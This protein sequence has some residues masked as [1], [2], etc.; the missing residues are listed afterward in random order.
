MKLAAKEPVIKKSARWFAFHLVDFLSMILPR[1]YPIRKPLS[2]PVR[3]IL[4][5]ELA[6]LGDMLLTTPLL[7]G[8]KDC[9]P[10]AKTTV[11]CTPWAKEAIIDHPNVD[12]IMPYEAFW[13]DRSTNSKPRFK[14]LISTFKLLNYF[15]SKD[16]DIAFLV[17]SR[18]QPFV[19]LIGYLSGACIRVGT[20]SPLGYRF[21]T[22]AVN[23]MDTHIVDIKKGLLKAVC[24]NIQD[25]KPIYYGITEESREKAARY[26]EETFGSGRPPFVCITPETSQVE[27]QW[28]MDLWADLINL[29]NDGGVNILIAGE[30]SDD[31]YVKAIHDKVKKQDLCR[32]IA[33]QFSL[34]QFAAIMER[35]VGIVTVES[36][37]MHLAAALDLPCVVL[38]SRMY[39]PN[40]F[41]PTHPSATILFKEVGCSECEK[42]CKDPI[43]MSFS[44]EEVYQETMRMI[45]RSAHPAGCTNRPN[46]NSSKAL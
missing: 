28:K 37:P 23:E 5:I 39:N 3:R 18:Q 40:R 35:S 19:T 33:G 38:F 24:P 27:K 41:K 12:E 15:R 14:H 20:K 21:L 13:E 4:L 31:E 32:N 10:H 9:F 29:L 11:L 43:C 7:T 6:M 1:V 44:V 17:T 2:F 22:H 45:H 25:N 42:G 16:F 26:I 30:R 46:R 34:N 8:I 36:A